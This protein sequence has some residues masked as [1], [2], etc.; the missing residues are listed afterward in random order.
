M[1]LQWRGGE[2]RGS[3]GLQ[4]HDRAPY[5]ILC[6]SP[7][8][9]EGGIALLCPST[10]CIQPHSNDRFSVQLMISHFFY[11]QII[12]FFIIDVKDMLYSSFFFFFLDCP[13]VYRHSWLKSVTGS[14]LP[15]YSF[16][17]VLIQLHT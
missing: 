6:C 8:Q 16:N 4:N 17:T 14:F 5:R 13:Q 7:T 12:F 2:Y 3:H 15:T 9:I 1:W 11:G 10:L